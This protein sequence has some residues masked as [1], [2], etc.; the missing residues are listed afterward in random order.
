MSGKSSRLPGFI[1][2]E[3]DSMNLICMYNRSEKSYIIIGARMEEKFW[4]MAQLSPIIIG[5]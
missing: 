4:K 2:Y 3:N 1:A 5:R